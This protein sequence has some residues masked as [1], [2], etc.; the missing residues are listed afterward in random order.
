MII[1]QKP[2]RKINWKWNVRLNGY[3]LTL[4]DQIKYLGLYLDKHLTGHYQSKLVM[5]K[6]ARA[7]GM[8]SKVRHY[9]NKAELKNIFHA[10]C[11]SQ[12]RYGCQILVSIKHSVHQRKSRK[13][14]QFKEWKILK[15][16]TL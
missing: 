13:T 6:L 16:K 2:N 1:F 9:V 4:S 10:I 11:E 15:S 7:L 12:L 5:Q 14:P 8:L 3:K